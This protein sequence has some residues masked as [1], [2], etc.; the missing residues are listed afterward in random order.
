MYW[1]QASTPFRGNAGDWSGHGGL[2]LLQQ[3]GVSFKHNAGTVRSMALPL[4]SLNEVFIKGPVKYQ[5]NAPAT[6]NRKMHQFKKDGIKFRSCL[7][8]DYQAYM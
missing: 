4:R 8:K 3:G 1:G 5:K 2:R 7:G 6:Y